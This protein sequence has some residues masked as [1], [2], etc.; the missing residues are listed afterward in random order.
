VP[1]L[2]DALAGG[3]VRGV[4][5]CRAGTAVPRHSGAFGQEQI[6]LAAG[7]SCAAEEKEKK[8]KKKKKKHKQREKEHAHVCSTHLHC[9]RTCTENTLARKLL[10][11]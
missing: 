4:P 11:K 8:R 2:G 7:M 9:K 6:S 1:N 10:K 3:R 5:P